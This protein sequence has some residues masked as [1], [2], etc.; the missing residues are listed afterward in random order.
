M[1]CRASEDNALAEE[2]RRRVQGHTALPR[3]SRLPL[4]ARPAA[5]FA[6]MRRSFEWLIIVVTWRAQGAIRPTAFSHRSASALQRGSRVQ[7]AS[8]QMAI[9]LPP[10]IEWLQRAG[11]TGSDVSQM[12]SRCPKLVRQTNTSELELSVSFLRDELNLRS[13]D[14]RKVTREAPELLMAASNM[15]DTLSALQSLGLQPKHLRAAVV[16]WPPLLTVRPEQVIQVSEF[17]ANEADF[18]RLAIASLYRHAPWV[19]EHDA[20]LRYR[21]AVQF[22]QSLGVNRT[23]ELNSRSVQ[24]VVRAFPRVRKAVISQ[25]GSM[26]TCEVFKG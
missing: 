3:G 13:Y 1:R 6:I 5:P 25:R 12:L 17:L 8:V 20:A 18:P 26:S 22:L 14:M 15:A 9:S 24:Y 21:P 11:Y 7:T 4:A 23:Q 2:L 16:R 10:A 19:L